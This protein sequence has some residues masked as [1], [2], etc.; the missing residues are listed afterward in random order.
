M[1]NHKNIIIIKTYDVYIDKDDSHSLLDV[2]LPVHPTP[3]TQNCLIYISSANARL[4]LP[5]PQ[6]ASAC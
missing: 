6:K 5:V 1:S 3:V 4:C 2:F